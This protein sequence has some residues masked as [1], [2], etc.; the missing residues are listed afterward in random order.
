MSLPVYSAQ[1]LAAEEDLGCVVGAIVIV[2]SGRK[3]KKR[4][5]Q[6]EKQPRPEDGQE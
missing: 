5:Q 3:G 6:G 2:F 4:P 1:C